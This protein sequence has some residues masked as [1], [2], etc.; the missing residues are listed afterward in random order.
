MTE[1]LKRFFTSINYAFKESDFEGASVQKVIYLK[2]KNIFEV[3]LE[4]QAVLPISIAKEILKASMNKINQEKEC[5]IHFVYDEI[6]HDDILVYLKDCIKDLTKKRPSLV[7]LM[8]A[9]VTI[10]DEII[11]LEVSTR[12]EEAEVKKEAKG[13]TSKLYSY[14]L[15]EYELTSILNE[16]LNREVKEDIEKNK[17]AEIPVILSSPKQPDVELLEG[18]V[19]S[20]ETIKKPIRKAIIEGYVLEMNTLEHE[21]VNII[22]LKIS[23]KTSQLSVKI[24][25]KPS[26]L[27]EFKKLKE[28]F[29]EGFWYRF[30]GRIKQ[31]SYANALILTV[32]DFMSLDKEEETIEKQEISPKSM[33]EGP[34]TGNVTAIDNIMGD[35][36]NITL[37]AYIFGKDVME[38]EKINI[39]TLKISD[40]TNSL[41]AK[42]FK[43]PNEKEEFRSIVKD[44]KEGTWYR[45]QGNV[46]RDDFAK[47]LVLTILKYESI[48][49][50]D[51][52]TM[53]QTDN[54]R[55]ELH[56]HTMMSAMD[57]VIDAK[58]LVK[59]AIKIGQKAIAV[60]DHNCVQ[61][62]PD[63]YHAVCDYNKGR[64]E[65]DRFKVLYGAEMN[66]VADD[67]DIIVNN[68]TYNLLEDTFVVFD[69]ETTGFY[70]GSDQ[71][72]EIGAVKI[73]SGKIVDRFD[74]L[75][76]PHRPIPK[77][78][79]ELTFITDEMLAGKDSE[80]NVTKRFLDWVGDLPMV[81]HNAKFDISFM[82]A[83]CNKY[84]FKEFNATVLDTMSMA[85]MLH[86]EWPNHKLQTLTKKLDIPW[87]EEKHHRADYDAEGTALAFHKM[88]KALYDQNIS[89]TDD[90]LANIDMESL[91]RFAFPFHATLIAKDRPGLKNLFKIVSIANTKYLYKN[92]Q[93][94]IPRKEVEA[95]R[96]GLLI[97]SGCI[98]GEIFDKASG[99]EDEELVNMMSFYDYIEVQPISAFSHLIGA[100]AKFPSVS[101][102]EEYL[103]RIIRVAK[104]AGKPVVATGDVH[105]LKKEDKIYREII[106]NQKFN[107]KLHPLKRKGIEVPNQYLKTTEEM[108]ED[109]SFLDEE[110]RK[111]IIIDN[112]NKIAGK[113]EEIEVIIDTPNPFAP[114]IPHS[115]E[116]MTELVYTKADELYGSPLPLNIEERLAKELYGDALIQACKNEESDEA[117]AFA[118]IHETILK[119]KEAVKDM[120]KKHLA[121]EDIQEKTEDEMDK[122]A[123]KKLGGII[124]ANYDVIY[125]IAQ[126]LVKHS[127]DE[128]FLV[129]SRGSVGSSFVANMMGITEVNSMPAHYRC[130]KCKNSIFNDEKGEPL[131]VMYSC[132]FDLPDKN[133]PECGEKMTKDGH[134]IPFATFLGFNADKVPDID[135]N[136]SDLN[137]A[138]AH[139]YTK[140][141]F[142]VD[143]VYRAGTIGTVAEKTAYGYVKGYCEEKGIIMRNIE[144]ERL[145]KGCTG[146]KRTTGQHPGG[147][148]VIPDYMEVAD[149]TPFQFPAEDPTSAW[150]TTHFDYHAIDADVLKLDILGHT[151]PTQLRMIQDLTG[152][153]VTEVPLDDKETMALF[154]GTDSLGVT[155]EEIMC[156]TGTLGVPEFGTPFT[157]QLV[158]DAKPTTFAELVKISG[159]AHGTDVWLGNAQ[160]LVQNNIC[161]FKDVIGCR[162]DIMVELM[163]KGVPPIKAF[164]IMEFVRKGKASREPDVWAEHAN[165]LKEYNIP[166]WYITSC[167]KIKY[168][169][170][171]AHAAAYVTSAF[172]IAWYKVHKP[173][174]YY[175]TYFST[176]FQ[177]FDPDAMVKGY[178]AI[179]AKILDI[180]S[181]GHEATN[182]DASLLETLKL[183]LEASAR[184]VRFKMIDIRES[185][186]NN[187][188][189][190][191]DENALILP[192]RSLDGL[193]DAVATKIMEERVQKQFY[194]VEDFSNRGK[195]N[196]STIEKMRI[197][198][199]FE[200][201]PETSQLSLF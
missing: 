39:L 60:T 191:E 165:T 16:E 89:T 9:L 59:H 82:R 145:A 64:E 190:V 186:G 28:E 99:K 96:E 130:P 143:N 22:T 196:Q 183:A 197:M 70:A 34:I 129:G 24:F 105:N 94:K 69:T 112:P 20:L 195:V 17:T 65:Q 158:K 40:K 115:V 172:R 84:H 169:F 188:V 149:F 124:G 88:A 107:G 41:L 180:Q 92:E 194:S 167:Q 75:I 4:F 25:K 126:K 110:T 102:A 71:M 66:V 43:R 86:P 61:A 181:K 147:I 116:T 76:D 10:E 48:E 74:E 155:K 144:T 63:L 139:E 45:F 78:I 187:F 7:N 5:A 81:A 154:T 176:R 133:C 95:L 12:M 114:K 119:G 46:K 141:L 192:F 156:D 200:G 56:T 201:M 159:L 125:L 150:R 80:E 178:D 51:E 38:H 117:K 35:I 83:A 118:L 27:E 33:N 170:P 123:F 132:G 142:G 100:D 6:S 182:K 18:E 198:G 32:N 30:S 164:K 42:V 14:G 15:G 189:M 131:G 19:T 36:A 47:D 166:D 3:Y 148:V 103:K 113:V 37:E 111:E 85:R 68:C 168:M 185:D 193:G 55:I 161:P 128:G 73:A 106:I 109:F 91:V 44:L 1:E 23:D 49:S 184:G 136:F 13:I 152:D 21:K 108:M 121:E 199:I 162:D 98:H 58:T 120:V 173:L 72:I 87:D 174:V 67:V 175:C 8:D 151:D 157:I 90:L 122:L 54:P 177:D 26:E 137:Q 31:D 29:R 62:F 77:K 97:G 104:E 11:T 101:A 93:P 171:K 57:G 153:D 140:V 79:T 2:Q 135:L 163:N 134:D 52:I 146:V 127:N 138:S 53:E 179:K 50:K 160:D